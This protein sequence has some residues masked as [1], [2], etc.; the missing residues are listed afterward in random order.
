MTWPRGMRR[1]GLSYENLDADEAAAIA[2]GSTATGPSHGVAGDGERGR[3]M[4]Y[5]L[6]SKEMLEEHIKK[7]V[8]LGREK[9]VF[10]GMEELKKATEG[11]TPLLRRGQIIFGTVSVAHHS[12]EDGTMVGMIA[13]FLAPI[14]MTVKTRQPRKYAY[15]HAAV[16]AGIHNNKHYV[17]ENGGQL[18]NGIGMISATPMENAFERDAKFF[19]LSP[20][21]DSEGRSTRYL[22]LQRALASLGLYYRYHMRA[23]SCEVFAMT[24]L[25]LKP[26]LEPIQT[27][28]LSPTKGHEVTDEKREEDKKKFEDFHANLATRINNCKWSEHEDWSLIL[29][30]RYYIDHVQPKYGDFHNLTIGALNEIPAWY[31]QI[32][33][34]YSKF[35]GAVLDNDIDLCKSL[36]NKG[37]NVNN[38]FFGRTVLKSAQLSGYTDLQRF[39]VSE[40]A[41]TN[42]GEVDL[43][44]SGI[45]R[46]FMYLRS[47]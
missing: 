3:V 34:D 37:L 43:G 14:L 27:E 40:G 22:V 16:Y 8:G 38:K 31:N 11:Q 17:I 24:L 20:P 6:V 5:G 26:K 15:L 19:V 25:K 33:E 13:N 44:A 32:K 29:S 7:V 9:T 28:A 4:R 2:N 30:L 46:Y 1:R 23:V 10:H 18:E 45:R 47:R 35:F 41:D 21:K 36:L 42:Q 12:G 39:L